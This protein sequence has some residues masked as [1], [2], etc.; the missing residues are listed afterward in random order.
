MNNSRRNFVRA[1]AGTG[2]MGLVSGLGL[3]AGRDAV[4]QSNDYKALVCVFL[5]GGND[6]HNTLIPY[7]LGGSFANTGM[8]SYDDYTALRPVWQSSAS[9][10]LGVAH[11]ALLPLQE[12]NGSVRYGMNPALQRLAAHWGDGKLAWVRNVGPLLG[13]L[14]R[15]SYY[16]AARPYGI[17]SHDDQQGLAMMALSTQ[18][19][20]PL[21]GG[22]GARMQAQLSSYRTSAALPDAGLVSFTGARTAWLM[23]DALPALALR[24]QTSLN[25]KHANGVS[26][27]AMA[28]QSG[29]RPVAKAYGRVVSGAY[30][31]GNQINAALTSANARSIFNAA[32]GVNSGLHDQL[33]SVAQFIDTRM[34]M[35]APGRQIFIVGIGGFDNHSDEYNTQSN[36]LSTLA[37]GLHAFRSTMLSLGL[38]Q[39]VTAFTMSDF[40]RTLRMNNSNGTDHAWASHHLVMGG[41]VTGG[42]Y[43]QEANWAPGALDLAP[44]NTD[45][46]V[47][48][49]VSYDQMGAKL[50]TWFGVPPSGLNAVF[51]NLPNFAQSQANLDFI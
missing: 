16:T 4:A 33:L 10:G 49:K 24:G 13:P 39:Q 30:A 43:G 25:L 44:T 17:Y 2:A 26:P 20:I 37:D 21:L 9:Q 22:W 51:P 32:R 50:A 45:N 7:S 29:G 48:P 5:F 28:A 36:L 31:H 18:S 1:M 6:G 3:W 46:A 14:D 19:E 27:L 40:G 34:S 23:S 38:D 41:A 35:G 42:I 12:A 11:G 47:I 15:S 8:N